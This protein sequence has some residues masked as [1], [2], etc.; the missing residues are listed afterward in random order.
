MD[1]LPVL[2]EFSEEDRAICEHQVGFATRLRRSAY[3][4]TEPT[5]STGTFHSHSLYF[6]RS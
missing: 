1:V 4:V 3:Y 5:K 6:G 2:T